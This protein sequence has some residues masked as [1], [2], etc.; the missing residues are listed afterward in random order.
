MTF[1]SEKIFKIVSLAISVLWFTKSF[2]SLII[3]C[4]KKNY[5]TSFHMFYS[6]MRMA[7]V[8][9]ILMGLGAAIERNYSTIMASEEPVPYK[10]IFTKMWKRLFLTLPIQ[11]FNMF[12]S[13]MF[14]MVIFNRVEVNK[15]LVKRLESLAQ[16]K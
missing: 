12:W 11:I 4:S 13:L 6:I 14:Y 8:A 3:Y 16:L 7:F 1:E 15:K 5:G 2:I 9:F 10:I